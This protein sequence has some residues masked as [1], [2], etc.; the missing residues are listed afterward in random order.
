MSLQM[1]ASIQH[2][3]QMIRSGL[4]PIQESMQ[5]ADIRNTL[6]EQQLGIV[7]ATLA[8]ISAMVE[9]LIESVHLDDEQIK[10]FETLL[11]DKR[12]YVLGM[13]NN[14]DLEDR[15]KPDEPAVEDLAVSDDTPE[16]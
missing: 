14:E 13:L 8:E 10:H 9:A 3:E 4:V 2:V 1:P 5:T 15:S 7:I 11:D 6:I 16:G 12:R